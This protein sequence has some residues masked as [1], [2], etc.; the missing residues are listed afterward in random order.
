MEEI[1]RKLIDWAKETYDFYYSKAKELNMDFY[2]QSDLTLLSEQAPVNL[3]VIGINPGY[4]GNFQPNRFKKSS[5]LLLG[6]VFNGKHEVIQEWKILKKL[7]S[8]LE[9]SSNGNLIDDEK[10]FVFTN[11]TFF[12]THDE[13]GLNGNVKEAQKESIKYT[14]KLI[15]IIQPKH[16]ICLGGKNCTDLLVS[17]TQPLLPNTA[18]LEYGR[19]DNIPVYGITHPSSFWSNE[20]M[21]LVGTALGEAFAIDSKPIDLNSWETAM[22]KPIERFTQKRNERKETK[23]TSQS[24]W[25]DIYTSLCNYCKDTLHLEETEKDKAWTWFFIKDANGNNRLILALINQNGDKSIAV[26]YLTKN[27][28]MDKEFE[29]I[30]SRLQSIDENFKPQTSNDRVIWIGKLDL[31]ARGK[32]TEAFV[33][34]TKKLL[35][36]I[37]KQLSTKRK[38]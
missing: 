31:N 14:K 12:S 10:T 32:D 33:N 27:H 16:I 36:S 2:T 28:P 38:E 15:E 1:Q 4:G 6:N 13:K 11:A 34:E 22:R 9:Y 21:E 5:D 30:L 23:L 19:I 18:R 17:K 35:D 26:R 3:M 25:Q 24:L 37:F 20:A 7:R 8:I 29:Q